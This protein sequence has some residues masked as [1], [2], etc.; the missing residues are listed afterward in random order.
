MT[1]QGGSSPQPMDPG[2]PTGTPAPGLPPPPGYLVGPAA[3]DLRYHRLLTRP[4]PWWRCLAAV[5]LG[6]LGLLVGPV[7]VLVV[8]ALGAKLLGRSLSFDLD[9]GL[10]A[11]EMLVLNLGLALL[12][13][14]SALSYRLVYRRSPRWLS[15]L[16][17]GLRGRWL[18]RCAGMAL[19]V[20]FLLMVLATTGAALDRD[21]PVDS[22]VVWFIVVVLLT[23]P[24]Q[25]AGEEYLFRGLVLQGLGST[26]LPTWV[27]CVVSAAL[28]ATAHG[29]FDPPLFADRFVI[30]VAFAYLTI[31][32]GGLEASIAVHTV[33]NL[34]GLIPAALLDDVSETLDPQGG[35]SWLPVTVDV[36]L[37]AI[38]VPW[39]LAV[40][41]SRLRRGE[42][43]TSYAGNVTS[44]SGAS[45]I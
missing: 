38:L 11:G 39:V 37:L 15:S 35:I 13:P 17:P 18:L 4:R 16:R 9:N 45:R 36:V 21:A 25:A 20:W 5:V 2:P 8:A 44:S 24:L 32:T 6:V 27:C 22:A 19:A 33:K 30:G 12:I 10:S 34:A 43:T 31:M 7:I 41:R 40:C 23:T 26:R 14:L 28:F 42:L 3:G 29:Q 1:D